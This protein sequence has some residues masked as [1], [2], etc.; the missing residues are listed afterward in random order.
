MYFHRTGDQVAVL[1]HAIGQLHHQIGGE[2]L[3]VEPEGAPLRSVEEG[4][5]VQLILTPLHLPVG[6]AQICHT[7]SVGIFNF[8]GGQA[9]IPHAAGGVF[10]GDGVQGVGPVQPRLAG[11]GGAGPVG[12]AD[13]VGQ[14][15]ARDPG[16]VV[17]VD[18]H[19]VLVGFHL[20]GGVLGVQSKNSIFLIQQDHRDTP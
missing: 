18:Q 13:Q 7:A 14:V 10:L 20:I 11:V 5:A 12:I 3:Q 1:K 4:Q 9:E 16:T 17:G 15:A 2:V 8:D 6:Q 19:I